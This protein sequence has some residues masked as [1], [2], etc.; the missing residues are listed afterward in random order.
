M[1]E[2]TF[3]VTIHMVASLDGFIAR[4]DGATDWMRSTDIYPEGIELTKAYIDEFLNA[5]DCYVMG[6]GTYEHALKLG[7]PYGDTPVVVL[8]GRSLKAKRKSIT[9]FSGNLEK[10]MQ[11][12]QAKYSN[13]WMVGGA[14]LTKSFL[15]ARLADEIVVTYIPILLGD[16]LPFFDHV[17]RE[18]RLH[19]KA[20][21]P[22]KDG[23]VELSYAILK[24]AP[25]V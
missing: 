12:L 20:V 22:F 8:T 7:W 4:K 25:G 21:T 23:M 15:I 17:G 9:F 14:A 18:Q 24:Q 5:I 11:Q 3:K 6:S 2:K 10:L 16:G 19:L 1:T 13:V